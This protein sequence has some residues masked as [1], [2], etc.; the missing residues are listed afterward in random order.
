M[1]IVP[2]IS[3]CVHEFRR[4]STRVNTTKQKSR[5]KKNEAK[6]KKLNEKEEE[7]KKKW[8]TTP[9]C[10]RDDGNDWNENLNH[11][12]RNVEMS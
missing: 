5:K 7:K 2:Y 9:Q 10:Q 6:T 8:A 12:L 1:F 3:V 4:K 11:I